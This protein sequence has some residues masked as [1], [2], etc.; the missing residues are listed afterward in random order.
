MD[1]R[2]GER[3][4]RTRKLALVVSLL[5]L[6]GLGVERLVANQR[7]VRA[8][9]LASRVEW[10]SLRDLNISNVPGWQ[11]K[12]AE[13]VAD[14]V[15]GDAAALR[16]GRGPAFVGR[17]LGYR[18]VLVGFS[19]R[20]QNGRAYYLDCPNYTEL[21]SGDKLE[22]DVPPDRWTAVQVRTFEGVSEISIDGGRWREVTPVEAHQGPTGFGFLVETG[23][24]C[25]IKD[26][27]VKVLSTAE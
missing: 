5:L 4:R 19:I 12:S 16:G 18:D 14:D 10:M 20:V 11:W 2:E 8:E 15:R 25:E 7:S 1:A 27:R 17:R 21:P 9:V 26:V 3:P 24:A 23:S 22:L 6:I 13:G